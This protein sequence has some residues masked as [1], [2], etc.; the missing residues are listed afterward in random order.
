LQL[1]YPGTHELHLTD[2]AGSYRAELI[3]HV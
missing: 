2:Q 3:L 1:Y